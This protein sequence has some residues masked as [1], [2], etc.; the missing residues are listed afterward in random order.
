MTITSVVLSTNRNPK[1]PGS[2][3]RREYCLIIVYLFPVCVV[4]LYHQRRHAHGYFVLRIRC[5]NVPLCYR[6]NRKKG[7]S[8]Q[9][10]S[11]RK[12]ACRV[13]PKYK[14]SGKWRKIRCRVDHAQ[15]IVRIE[16]SAE[17]SG[18]R[19]N[20]L[21]RVVTVED[22]PSFA[23]EAFVTRMADLDFRDPFRSK[24]LVGSEAASRD[25][26]QNRIYDITT[27]TL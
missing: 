12:K 3:P 22:Q 2:L 4:V 19:P 14:E 18:R 24:H 7:M 16:P 13:K 1:A 21:L 9:V 25:R 5:R 27:L 23:L 15:S 26:V 17:T 8:C 20:S 10:S 11:Y 6:I